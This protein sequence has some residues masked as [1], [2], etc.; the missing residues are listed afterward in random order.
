MVSI[1]EKQTG[2]TF[3]TWPPIPS[4]RKLVT[5]KSLHDSDTM[6]MHV[7]C[8][9]FLHIFVLQS[10]CLSSQI[11]DRIHWS[12]TFESNFCQVGSKNSCHICCTWTLCV[13]SV[14]LEVCTGHDIHTL[15]VWYVATVV[16]LFFHLSWC[17]EMGLQFFPYFT[18]LSDQ[19]L[20]KFFECNRALFILRYVCSIEYEC[21]CDH[22][23]DEMKKESVPI[24]ACFPKNVVVADCLIWLVNTTCVQVVI[25]YCWW[26]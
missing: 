8:L 2:W 10:F 13:A 22:N 15:P 11:N 16:V 7:Y 18:Q 17:G 3:T 20:L 23:I 4:H 5:A 14:F 19:F 12:A 21:I 9:F 1:I 26:N 25:K 24:L 6:Y